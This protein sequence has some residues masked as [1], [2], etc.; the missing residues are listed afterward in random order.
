MLRLFFTLL[1]YTNF[2]TKKGAVSYKFLKILKEVVK[3]DF[4]NLLL[5]INCIIHRD[6]L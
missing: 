4:H 5:N 1:Y 3:N 2:L 6:T